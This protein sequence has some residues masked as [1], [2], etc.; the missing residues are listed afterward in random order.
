MNETT[1]AAWKNNQ[2][3]KCQ[4]SVTTSVNGKQD[5]FHLRASKEL[6][7]QA[8]IEAIEA[9]IMSLTRSQKASISKSAVDGVQAHGDDVDVGH[10]ELRKAVSGRSIFPGDKDGFLYFSEGTINR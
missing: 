6:E 10:C 3:E 1:K 7:G 5:L 8:W 2:H 9:T 4:F